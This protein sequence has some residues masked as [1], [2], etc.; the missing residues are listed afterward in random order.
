MKLLSNAIEA[1]GLIKSGNNIFIHGGDS[2]PLELESKLTE[3]ADRVKDVTLYHLHTH[4]KAKYAKAE[5][6]KAFNVKNLFVG[7]N[8]RKELNYDNVDYLPCFLSEIPNLFLRGICPLDIALIQVSPPDKHGYMSLGCSVDVAKAAAASAKLVIAQINKQVPRVLGDGLLHE[9]EI[10]YAFEFN[11]DI[12]TEC[13]NNVSSTD[14]KIGKSVS[15]LIENGST[16]Q[17]GI[18]SVPD[19]VLLNLKSHKDLGVHTEMWT[20]GMLT[21]LESGVV[22]NKLKKIE[23]GK[24]LSSFIIGDKEVHNYIDDNPNIIQKTSDYVNNPYIIKQNPKVCAINSAVEI[25]LTGQICADSIGREVISGVGGQMDF[26]RGASLSDGGKPIIALHS[27]TSR[28]D[29]KIV[30][31]LKSGAGVVT[32]RAHVHYIVTEYGVANLVGKT[33][34]ERA[35][36]LTDIA[37]PDHRQWLEKSWY[38][39][40][41]AHLKP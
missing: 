5:Y 27:T 33:L 14:L 26:M 34:K 6:H 12:T 16:L 3:I 10:D 18:G 17:V 9:S 29:S 23:S 21:L 36:A 25:D 28:G 30:P 11:E 1:L 41:K 22:N 24:T 7:H 20:K 40:I 4:G 37:H 13:K 2:T 32:T 38:E 15:E 8:V 31:Y 39:M 19:A 35:K